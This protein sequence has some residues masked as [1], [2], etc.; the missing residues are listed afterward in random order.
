MGASGNRA[1]LALVRHR[2]RRHRWRGP[3]AAMIGLLSPEWEWAGV[4]KSK[5]SRQTWEQSAPGGEPG[6]SEIQKSQVCGNISTRRVQ[7]TRLLLARPTQYVSRAK[8]HRNLPVQS[9]MACWPGRCLHCPP[10][11]TLALLG[12][13]A[14]A[15]SGQSSHRA[16]LFPQ[17]V[18]G[19]GSGPDAGR[20]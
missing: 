6:N 12:S 18:Y 8:T 17:R 14:R 9:Q 10:T 1:E 11:P 20:C 3:W 7:D 2:P 5:P 19:R 16:L 13:N 4:R 15:S